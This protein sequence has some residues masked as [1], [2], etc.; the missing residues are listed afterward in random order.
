MF[1]MDQMIYLDYNA[2]TPI[3]PRVAEAML[4]YLTGFFGNPS[5]SHR[6]G[7]EAKMAVDNSRQHVAD[8]LGC[9]SDEVVFTSGGT[10]SNNLAIVGSLASLGWGR[11]V[12]T[13]A[14]EHPAVLEVVLALELEGKIDLSVVGVDAQ[15]RV[16]TA[17]VEASL[18]PDTALVTLMLANNE[19]GTLQPVAE[20]ASVCRS[21]GVLMHTDAAQAVGKIPV[22]VEELGVDLL[23]VAGH[24][25]YA[26]KGV[27]ALYVR[28][29]VSLQL[30]LRGEGHEGG[31]RPGTE[32]VLEQVGLGA[33]CSLVQSELER[34]TTELR[35][36]RDQLADRFREAIPSSVFHGNP[37]A[38]LPNTLSVGIPGVDAE[39]L[40]NRLSDDV[41]ASAG[42]ACHADER[43]KVSHVLAA[44][45]I[46][47][48]V[49]RSTIRLS[50]GRMTTESDVSRGAE[51]IVRAARTIA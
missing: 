10:E 42:A 28:R 7:R 43:V 51:L 15:G 40:L 34:E 29:G 8:C 45:G 3:D 9:T 39:T 49:A 47:K 5:S 33:A 13:S 26:P 1:D 20:V 14:V 23:S 24:K 17:E 35:V 16:D 11:H 31:V 30:V 46:S 12:V 32:N 21:R 2:T 19:V 6:L 37:E 27:G 48:E 41:A 50:V 44:M 36:K 18:R 38:G 22:N 25:L 4:P